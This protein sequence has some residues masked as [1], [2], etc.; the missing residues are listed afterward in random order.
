[1]KRL[2]ASKLYISLQRILC[3]LNCERIN[4]TSSGANLSGVVSRPNQGASECV[5]LL[6]PHP[7]YG[8]DM[9]NTVVVD[10]ER[11]FLELEYATVR[12][13]FRGVSGG[14]AGVSCAV[15]DATKA[16]D[17]IKRSGLSVVGL[18]GYS[19]GGSVAL[20]LA[21][22]RSFEFV[23]ALSASLN[24]F[25]DGDTDISLLSKLHCPCLLFH[26][27]ADTMVPHSDVK[28]FSDLLPRVKTVA[29]ENENHFYE[30]SL[31]GVKEEIRTFLA[32]LLSDND[33]KGI[34]K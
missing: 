15:E 25:L 17:F 30:S 27:L 10:L 26:G 5:L 18:V 33:L 11:I 4:I 20:R 1:M 12:F 2:P 34:L 22:A 24:L 28:K 31:P 14:Y 21:C 32:S 16:M 29:L 19:F 8:G 9:S 23:I 6:H 3:N 13:N 7:L